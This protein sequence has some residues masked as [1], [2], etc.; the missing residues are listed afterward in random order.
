MELSLEEKFNLEVD[1]VAVQAALNKIKDIAKARLGEVETL[2]KCFSSIDLTTLNTTD[3]FERGKLFADNVSKF[4]TDF[5][6]M[7]N[8]AAIC[9][10][11][12]IV[13]AV[14]ENLTADNVKIASVSAGF[15]SSQTYID[16]KLSECEMTIEQGADELDVV[17]SVGS[18]LEGDY[19]TVFSELQQ[20]KEV[21][22]DTKVKV[23]LETGALPSLEDIKLASF[24]AMEA[25]ADFIKTSTGKL[26]PAATPES[27]YVMCTAIKEY[28][29]KTG[30][31]VGMKP[32]GGVSN[33][34]DALVFYT[35]VEQVLGQEWLYPG[36]FR[37]GTSKLADILL[38]D[39]LGK[40]VKYFSQTSGAKY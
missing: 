30:R 25:G 38:S 26:E 20:I 22:E 5:P 15:P 39:I 4:Q 37:L 23:I 36:L 28:F 40:E 33:S 13:P 17:M 27:V 12:S 31:K 29:D 24:L 11:P 10:Y 16:I 3:G 1:Q 35:I 8:V 2:K 9:V 7:P 34:Y 6:G 19:F 14:K 21:A 18:F 32:A